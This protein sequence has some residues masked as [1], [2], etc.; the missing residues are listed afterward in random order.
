MHVVAI[1]K[2]EMLKDTAILCTRTVTLFFPP[3]VSI[4]PAIQA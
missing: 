1:L 2:S 3:P 4:D